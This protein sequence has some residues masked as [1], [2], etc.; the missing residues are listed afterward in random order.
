MSALYLLNKLEDFDQ[1]YT[2]TPMG[3]GKEVMVTFTSFSRPHQ[4]FE[5]QI[6]AKTSLS[7]PYMYLLNQMVDS[8][9]TLCIVS[10]G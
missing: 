1:T 6:L 3:L 7:V 10:L 4:L 5:C 9:Q 8:G 2:E